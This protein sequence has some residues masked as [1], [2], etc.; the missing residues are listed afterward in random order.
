MIASSARRQKTAFTLIE[1]LVVIAIIG[2]L[3]SLLLPAV[4][5]V[6]E[7]ARRTECL[8]N[9]KQIGL[10]S[11]NFVSAQGK[12]PTAG[13]SDWDFW[14]MQ[15]GWPDPDWI[16]GM[17]VRNGRYESAGW[18]FQLLEFIEQDNLARQRKDFGWEGG[19]YPLISTS[20]STYNC[21]S[22]GE[23]F[24]V[25]GLNAVAL[26]DYA[27]IMGSENDLPDGEWGFSFNEGQSPNVNEA[28]FVWS[29]IISRGGH[30]DFVSNSGSSTVTKFPRVTF[31]S[32]T[33]GSSNTAMIMEKA[34]AV[35][36]WSIPDTGGYDFWELK[37]YYSGADWQNMRVVTDNA[38]PGTNPDVGIISDSVPR[39]QAW[40][41]YP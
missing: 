2:I 38:G 41:S 40:H 33:D 13:G 10:A 3:V 5:Q 29:G 32:I 20:I 24:G 12:F 31:A 7:A 23:R 22:R 36:N 14:V 1:L 8:N 21:P 27:G 30:T 11:Q 15:N 9:L 28:R 17:S 39:P 19:D 34:V 16:N 35:E 4:Q 6:R 25:L 26:G 18:S 37:G